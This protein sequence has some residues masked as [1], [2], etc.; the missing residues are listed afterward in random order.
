MSPFDPD[1]GE[2]PENLPFCDAVMAAALLATDPGLGGILLRSW[3]GPARDLW[4]SHAASLFGA[5]PVRKLPLGVSEDRL[6]GGLDLAA[7]LGTGRPVRMAGILEQAQGGVLVAAMAE[8]LPPGTA[9]RIA[10]AL[11]AGGLAVIALDEGAGE[12]AVPGALAD[13]L[14]FTLVP[15]PIDAPWP[16]GAVIEAA[17]ARVAG[18]ATPSAA[19]AQLAALAEML[20]VAGLRAAIFA[21]RAARASAALRGGT[22]VAEADIALGA[23]LVLAPR[24]TRQPIPDSAPQT[25]A[26]T[27]PEQSPKGEAEALEDRVAE[28]QSA[29][30]P[31]ELLAALAAY[32][33]PRRASRGAGRAGN[34]DSLQRGRPAGSRRGTL[35]GHARLHLLDT[36]R[37]AAP[38]SRLRDPDFASRLRDPD[39]ASRLRDP[40]FASRLP[41]PNA[42]P[43]RISVR[44]EDFRIR[45]FREQPRRL[46]IF[47]VDASGSSALN[48]L[49]EAKGAIQLLLADCYVRRDEV[50]LIAF[51]GLGAEV[52]LPPTHA[53]A[54]ARRALAALPGG[55]PTP[56]AAG[57][58]AALALAKAEQRGAK[59]PL[60]VIL[61]DGGANIAADGSP[62]RAAAGRDALAAARACGAA[63][64]PALVVDIAPRGQKFVAE[65]ATAMQGRY[66]RLPYADAGRLAQAVQDG[67]GSLARRG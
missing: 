42:A 52:L 37:A 45:R 65:L 59:Q 48:R 39:F 63:G 19:F 18:V 17:R 29:S 14:A 22:E 54:R 25:P 61:T 41:P 9:A 66:L 10:A 36:L 43:R 8:R 24:A 49:A 58:G 55:G 35:T 5:V 53:L 47:A 26:E 40:D 60:L 27:P 57:L 34:A 6:M 32:A 67:G 62:G 1:W 51:R 11:D 44:A 28:V 13:R 15:P 46:A 56:L 12:E 23:R 21:Q 4:L 33:G 2:A 31:P 50:A 7:T 38:W 3:S 30:L 20:G 16:A 64:V